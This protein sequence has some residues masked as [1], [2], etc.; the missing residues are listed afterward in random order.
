L[1]ANGLLDAT[2]DEQQL[3][4][5]WKV[6]PQANLAVA[7]GEAS[8]L[9]VIDID[10]DKGGW[11]SLLELEE[12]HGRPPETVEVETGGGGIHLYYRYPDGVKIGSRN[13]WRPG[14]DVKADGGYVIAPPSNHVK[15]V[16]H[17]ADG[18][19]PCD[20]ELAD[21]PPWLLE[22]LPRKDEA[23]PDPTTNGS[24]NGSHKFTFTDGG[25]SLVQRAEAYV[26][27][28]EGA[29][30]GNRNDTAF[31]LAGHVAALDD[32]GQRLS[33]GEIVALLST[34][35]L[36]NS[37]PLSDAELLTCIRS[38]LVNGTARPAK[39]SSVDAT[40]NATSPP[41]DKFTFA[42]LLADSP[43]LNPPVVH[44]LFREGETVN[45]VSTS[46]VG[47][48]WLAYNL[49]LSVI[50]GHK[51]LERFETERGRVLLIDNE[52][53][54]GT[55]TN[56]I[57]AVAK[58]LGIQPA[59]YAKDLEVWPL[60]GNLRNLIQLGDDFNRIEPGRYKVIVLDAKYRFAFP[61][62]SENDNAAETLVY[63]L[64]DQYA[65]HTAAAFVL[66]HH[67]SKGNQ[68]EKRVTDVGAGAGA[69]SRAAD[70]HLVLRE[71][72]Q[73]DV[74]VLDAAVRS[75]A[76]VEPLALQWEFPLWRPTTADVSKLKGR[77]NRSE[78]RQQ[79]K[80]REGKEATIKALRE[81]PATQKA[82]R[83]KTGYRQ[84]RQENLL[85]L[86]CSEGV[87]AYRNV[88][89][90]GNECREYYLTS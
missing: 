40:S 18:R 72:E 41:C 36:R 59:A 66:V 32:N 43:T 69:Q 47:K 85:N 24:V 86:L 35:N 34:W 38:A 50:A 5:W 75:F 78:E 52:L 55:L 17:W 63:N 82:L 27:K 28:A 37:P 84:E 39:E 44:G 9:V 71:H 23:K 19:R 56:R 90:R 67:T 30:K 12:K 15:G 64:L 49:G 61:G 76:P 73:P 45:L 42:E 83:A 58:E 29:S 81:S 8:G 87:V 53:H 80:D 88:I 77:L 3:A 62:K 68:G 89:I 60:R 1:T 31:R 2:T 10:P 48:S 46:K 79:A 22:L 74:A 20:V 13:G 51:W 4:K 11:E 57:P 16:Y 7:T 65:A 6:N 54:R 21:I 33:E 25:A 26:A 70:C 14:V